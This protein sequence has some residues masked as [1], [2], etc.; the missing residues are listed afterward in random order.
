MVVC[1]REFDLRQVRGFHLRD[2]SPILMMPIAISD[3][4]V[5]HEVSDEQ[6]QRRVNAKWKIGKVWQLDEIIPEHSEDA[7]ECV[8]PMTKMIFVFQTVGSIDVASDEFVSV[9]QDRRFSI[10]NESAHQ[11][12]LGP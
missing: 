7:I 1:R 4:R 2:Q 8:L 3:Q 9:R 6:I 5:K 11:N 10:M 12:A